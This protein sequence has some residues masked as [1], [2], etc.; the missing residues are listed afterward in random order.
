MPKDKPRCMSYKKRE[1][2]NK[3]NFKT[4]MIFYKDKKISNLTG[5]FVRINRNTKIQFLKTSAKVVFNN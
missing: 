5:I 4:N 3:L 2:K 1:C